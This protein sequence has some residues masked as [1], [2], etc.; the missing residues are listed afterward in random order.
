VL[1]R[2]PTQVAAPG[3][4]TGAAM[5]QPRETASTYGPLRLEEQPA[6]NGDVTAPARMERS[7][8][9]ACGP[10]QL[11]RGDSADL[12]RR[13][14]APP[15]VRQSWAAALPFA[16]RDRWARSA[17]INERP[18]RFPSERSGRTLPALWH[19]MRAARRIETHVSVAQSGSVLRSCGLLV[20]QPRG[21]GHVREARSVPC[22]E[23]TGRFRPD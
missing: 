12:D 7:V 6:H 17:R 8:E 20:V 18:T 15:A 14:D 3:V 16:S 23:Q 10:S 5:K 9:V 4:A 22:S 21:M 19:S 2:S 1:I 13:R 11:V